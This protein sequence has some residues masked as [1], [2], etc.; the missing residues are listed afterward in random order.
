M[1]K[2]DIKKVK[3]ENGMWTD[4]PIYKFDDALPFGKGAKSVFILQTFM[5]LLWKESEPIRFYLGGHEYPS[6]TMIEPNMPKIFNESIYTLLIYTADLEATYI[7]EKV[8]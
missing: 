3:D 6:D 7:D 8:V 2:K 5:K 1:D 4:V